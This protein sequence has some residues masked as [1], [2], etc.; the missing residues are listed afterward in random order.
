MD[1]PKIATKIP[2]LTDGILDA[3][4]NAPP[5]AACEK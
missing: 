5:R 3:W 2:F 1:F 4:L